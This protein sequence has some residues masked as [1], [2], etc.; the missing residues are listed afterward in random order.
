MAVD[1]TDLPPGLRRSVN[2]ATVRGRR[3]PQR[4]LAVAEIPASSRAATRGPAPSDARRSIAPNTR[5]DAGSTSTDRRG[6]HSDTIAPKSDKAGPSVFCSTALSP[7]SSSTAARRG[8]ASRAGRYESLTGALAAG[9][10]LAAP[11]P[12]AGVHLAPDPRRE[13]PQRSG[14]SA[15][16]SGGPACWRRRAVH[17][18]QRSGDLMRAR[19][20]LCLF[21]GRTA[22]HL[23][24]CHG[25]GRR[26]QLPRSGLPRPTG[27][28]SPRHGARRLAGG[29]RLLG[30]CRPQPQLAAIAPDQSLP[31]P[32]R[33]AP[34]RQ[35]RDPP[36]WF[37]VQ[38]GLTLGRIADDLEEPE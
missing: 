2:R 38:L 14:P 24:P 27:E 19:E 34:R 33:P 21:F 25:E 29:A 22:D 9:K 6:K 32:A 12:G 35:L 26:G 11:I 1:Q 4:L 17:L 13:V 7:S 8:E 23:A 16:G 30:R 36:P 28:A 37:L 20:F 31:H 5:S 10:D 3:P 15:R 18:P